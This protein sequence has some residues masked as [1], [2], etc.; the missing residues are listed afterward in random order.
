MG[1]G[2]GQTLCV[3]SAD[4][5][6]RRILCAEEKAMALPE[7]L[8]LPL[9]LFVFPALLGV[10]TLPVVVMLGRTLTSTG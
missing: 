5:R 6:Q 10:L 7:K 9:I 4:M 3:F 8:T 2:L 1:T